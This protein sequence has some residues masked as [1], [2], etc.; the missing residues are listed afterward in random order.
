MRFCKLRAGFGPRLRRFRGAD[1][2]R[3]F[4]ICHRSESEIAQLQARHAELQARL[5][6][7]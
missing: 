2:D 7:A 1:L 5:Q 3:L 4:G 6:A